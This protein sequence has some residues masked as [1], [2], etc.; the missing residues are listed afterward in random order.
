M[1]YS[2]GGAKKIPM[3]RGFTLVE[4]LVVI[5]IIGILAALLLPALSKAKETAKRIKC[6]G[7][8]KQNGM[9]VQNY[10]ADWK[11]WMD[12]WYRSP[13]PSP[14]GQGYTYWNMRIAPYMGTPTR[15]NVNIYWCP[16]SWRRADYPYIFGGSN[17]GCNWHLR[18]VN[19]KSTSTKYMILDHVG[20][21][22]EQINITW[23]CNAHIPGY[24]G[25]TGTAIPPNAPTSAYYINDLLYGRHGRVINIVFVDG[26]AETR[27]PKNVYNDLWNDF[28][29]S[30]DPKK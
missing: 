23:S 27:L 16:S 15:H 11:G 7:H 2:K 9:G 3:R 4:L 22:F 5:A 28:P 24:F 29:R 17:Y 18:D 14:F 26:H 1:R 21:L 12:W 30:I 20:T 25:E 10:T 6:L 13:D 19:I 8:L